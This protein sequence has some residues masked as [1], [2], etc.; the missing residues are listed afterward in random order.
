MDARRREARVLAAK[1]R[2][3]IASIPDDAPQTRDERLAE[4]RD[5][6]RAA[7]LAARS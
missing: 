5:F 3:I 7:E 1:A 2:S 6:R 4:A